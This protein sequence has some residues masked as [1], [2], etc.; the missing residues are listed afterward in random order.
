MPVIIRNDTNPF[1]QALMA[2]SQGA[3]QQQLQ[4]QQIEAQL[5]AQKKEKNQGTGTGLVGGAVVGYLSGGPMGAAM[6]ALK[7]M[8][9]GQQGGVGGALSSVVGIYEQ[10]QQL[11]ARS[12]EFTQHQTNMLERQDNASKKR[13]SEYYIEAYGVDVSQLG[14]EPSFPEF[15]ANLNAIAPLGQQQSAIDRW[16]SPLT[17]DMQQLHRDY[18]DDFR[19]MAPPSQAIQQQQQQQQQQRQ[20]Q[21]GIQQAAQQQQMQQQMQQMQAQSEER[22]KEAGMIMD[23]LPEDRRMLSQLAAAKQRIYS[24]SGWSPEQQMDALTQLQ[25]TESRIRKKAVPKGPPTTWQEQIDAGLVRVEEDGAIYTSGDWKSLRKPSKPEDVAMSAQE[26]MDLN[27]IPAQDGK[28][29]MQYNGKMMVPLYEKPKDDPFVEEYRLA[30]QSLIPEGG[31]SPTPK[32]VQNKV[33]ETRRGMRETQKAIQAEKQERAEM[34]QR[35]QQVP[36]AMQ[37]IQQIAQQMGTDDP[38]QWTPEAREQAKP[39]AMLISQSIIEQLDGTEATPE[40]V[41]MLIMLLEIIES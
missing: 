40:Q 38:S 33:L 19:A 16:I 4:N 2:Y 15:M 20:Q 1:L 14:Q 29:A 25:Q 28:P 12:A 13:I 17:D 7:G 8:A 21:Q 9:G 32:A 30:E 24:N 22:L 11:A 39:A 23:Y 34:A 6:G 10:Q 27:I 5:A 26:F 3:G 36:E 18:V 41:Q 37:A 31:K 35:Q